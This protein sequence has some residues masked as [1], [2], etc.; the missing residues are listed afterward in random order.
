MFSIAPRFQNIRSP[1]VDPPTSTKP[2][3]GKDG[4]VDNQH[5]KG[6]PYCEDHSFSHLFVP[7]GNVCFGKF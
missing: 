3:D 7:P 1:W 6:F 2:D 5:A 4:E